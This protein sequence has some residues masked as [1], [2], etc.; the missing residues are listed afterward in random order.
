MPIIKS[1]RYY[2]I[3]QYGAIFLVRR[4]GETITFVNFV[5]SPF[6]FRQNHAYLHVP[7]IFLAF[8]RKQKTEKVGMD[9]YER[10]IVYCLLCLP[11]SPP[12]FLC[13]ASVQSCVHSQDPGAYTHLLYL[14]YLH[15]YLQLR[16][17]K[18]TSFIGFVTSATLRYATFIQS[19]LMT[20]CF[21][22]SMTIKNWYINKCCR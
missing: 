1:K 4:K 9:A 18:I 16:L 22:V 11:L 12:K 14:M 6:E 3:G 8:E 7:V 15:P 13:R 10:K 19:M 20:T 17:S 2:I 21:I 5:S